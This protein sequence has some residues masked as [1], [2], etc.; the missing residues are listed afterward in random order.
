MSLDY[1]TPVQALGNLMRQKC[2]DLSPNELPSKSLDSLTKIVFTAIR[3]N[4]KRKES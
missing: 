2:P 1:F 4:R 3:R